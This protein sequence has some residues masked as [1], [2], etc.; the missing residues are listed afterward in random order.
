MQSHYRVRRDT[1]FPL[2]QILTPLKIALS[3]VYKAATFGKLRRSDMAIHCAMA[4]L[5]Q[6]ASHQKKIQV[7]TF[8]QAPLHG[9][10]RPG[11]IYR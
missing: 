9:D 4:Q 3:A 2:L 7:Y 5:F 11:N 1:F 8:S 10:R 6:L